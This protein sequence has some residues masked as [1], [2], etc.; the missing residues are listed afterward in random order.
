MDN[1]NIIYLSDENGNELGFEYLDT[2]DYE[3]KTY[4]VL[5]PVDEDDNELVVLEV[6]PGENEN[7]EIFSD[8]MDDDILNAVY[9]IF[10]ENHKDEFEADE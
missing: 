9:D 8:V 7:E 4:A 1:E 2:I 5:F 3:G 10:M 6:E